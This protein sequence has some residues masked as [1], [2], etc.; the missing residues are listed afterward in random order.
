MGDKQVD[1]A[2]V[3]DLYFAIFPAGV[4]LSLRFAPGE[5]AD[6]V[7]AG[8]VAV[9]FSPCDLGDVGLPLAVIGRG[10]RHPPTQRQ[11]QN[12]GS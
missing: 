6:V 3:A 4:E 9:N 8:A 5:V 11:Q 1:A 10:A 12:D 7:E 2:E